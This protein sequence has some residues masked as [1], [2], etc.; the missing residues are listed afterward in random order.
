MTIA[1]RL[2]T[3][4]TLADIVEA[5]SVVSRYLKPT[6]TLS[7]PGLNATLGFD[8]VLKCENLQPYGAFKIRGGIYF[9]SQLD[10]EER[11]RGVVTASSGNHG[12]S[13]AFAA[14]M[15]GVPA[16]VF[17]PENPNPVK[18]GAIER[19]GA[20]IFEIPWV[21]ETTEDVPRQYAEEHGMLL[22]HG[23][24]NA[25][26]HAGV[27]TYA[28]ELIEQAPDLD[29]IYVPVGGGSGVCATATVFKAMRPQTKIVG[30]QARNKPAVFEAFHRKEIVTVRGEY[31][32]AEGL[33]TDWAYELPFRV[34]Q[35]LVDDVVLV[36]DE[37]LRQAIV[38][39]MTESHLVVEPSGAAAF[40]AARND[41]SQLTG[42]KVG[43]VIS[44][45][46]ASIETLRSALSD[47]RW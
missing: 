15:L 13:V 27:G 25:V 16:V 29:V 24:N 28:L 6:P 47:E 40:A 20:E 8:A 32:R 35:D 2:L 37:D 22:V 9:M 42:M 41:A 46:N 33:A 7:A 38:M 3:P 43:I 18:R 1:D 19:M 23:I 26:L 44:G 11:E 17:M 34:M 4:A 31:T 14:G 21:G 5:R 30:V 10:D 12:Q 39:L 45:G 36:D